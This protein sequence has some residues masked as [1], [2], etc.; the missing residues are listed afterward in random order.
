MRA[1]LAV[2][3]QYSATLREMNRAIVQLVSVLSAV[4]LCS[5]AP[6]WNPR[7]AFILSSHNTF[8]G[9]GSWNW[10][11]RTSNGIVRDE[12]GVLRDEGTPEEAQEVTG[13]YSWTAPDGVNYK[14]E[15]TGNKDGF[16]ALLKIVPRPILAMDS[17]LCSSAALASL[18]CG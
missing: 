8:N 4:T 16:K 3:S 12:S 11:F 13:S 6:Q 18:A 1:E 9:L 14:V 17:P 10:G 2:S 7:N 15:Y 5:A